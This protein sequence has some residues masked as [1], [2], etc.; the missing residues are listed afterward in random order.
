VLTMELLD[1]VPVDDEAGIAALGVDA[2]PAVEQVVKAWF[3]T[4]LDGGVFHGDVHA[5][6]IMILRDGR[7]AL[8][9]WGIVG[10]LSAEDHHLFRQ[11]IRGALGDR[12][13]AEEVID[14]ALATWMPLLS[15]QA[16]VDPAVLRH[17]LLDQFGAPLRQ[18]IGEVSLADVVTMPQREMTRMAAE[19]GGQ[20][21][22][23]RQ[24]RRHLRDQDFEFPEIDRA[25]ILLGKQLAYFE[26]IGKLHLADIPVLHDEAFFAD[27]VG[28]QL[29]G[30]SS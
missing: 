16:D 4:A 15:A 14:D 5:G 1:G 9:D 17:F 12:T 10:R 26:R 27:L 25:F 7:I 22:S 13:A 21:R 19:G 8:L 28:Y 30:G 11:M 23:R 6:N 20:V 3:L 2:R 24:Q 29:P 18:P